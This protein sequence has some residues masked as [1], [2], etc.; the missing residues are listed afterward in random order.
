[1]RLVEIASSLENDESPE[2]QRSGFVGWRI[3][4]SP[5]G[6]PHVLR[7]EG[8]VVV[9]L[10]LSLTHSISNGYHTS[11]VLRNADGQNVAGWGTRGLRL[12][13]GL[14][15]VFYTLPNLPLRPGVYYLYAALWDPQKVD[16]TVFPQELVIATPEH[17]A[18][19]E[20]W[21]GLLNL[22]CTF[23]VKRA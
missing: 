13:A 3:A 15:R 7:H 21:A 12:E 4:N 17:S 14:H 1:M 10:T 6:D 16:E 22:P 11:M 18:L 23:E 9:E 8:E 20:E 19:A 2:K 5:V